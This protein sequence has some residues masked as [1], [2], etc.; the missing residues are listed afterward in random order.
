MAGNPL[1]SIV[2]E[3]EA[4]ASLH[5]VGGSGSS[6]RQDEVQHR[7]P[8]TRI[9]VPKQG[10]TPAMPSSSLSNTHSRKQ[11]HRPGKSSLPKHPTLFSAQDRLYTDNSHSG[12]DDNLRETATRTLNR[13]IAKRTPSPNSQTRTQPSSPSNGVSVVLTPPSSNHSKGKGK[14]R[15]RETSSSR[16]TRSNPSRKASKSERRASKTDIINLDSD[17][18][19][20][21]I[22]PGSPPP[23]R[24]HRQKRHSGTTDI[25]PALEAKAKRLKRGT[26]ASSA[27]SPDLFYAFSRDQPPKGPLRLEEPRE[28][29]KHDSRIVHVRDS[30]SPEPLEVKANPRL[31]RSG[32]PSQKMVDRMHPRNPSPNATAASQQ[33]SPNGSSF[34]TTPSPTRSLSS[35]GQPAESNSAPHSSKRRRTDQAASPLQRQGDPFD[36]P[37]EVRLKAIVVS[38]VWRS[39]ED[40]RPLAVFQSHSLSFSVTPDKQVKISYSDIQ[41]VVASQEEVT[42]HATL[43]F[44]LRCGSDSAGRV[45]KTFSDYDPRASGGAAEIQLIAK[46]EEID[47]RNHRMAVAFVIKKGLPKSKSDDFQIRWLNQPSSKSKVGS[48]DAVKQLPWPQ[49]KVARTL[50]FPGSDRRH[51]SESQYTPRASASFSS[52]QQRRKT[53]D[54]QPASPKSPAGAPIDIDMSDLSPSRKSPSL[55]PLTIPKSKPAT[56]A[57]PKV[58]TRHQILAA[59]TEQIL[60]YPYEGV[61][62]MSING[63]DFERLLDGQLLNDIIIEFGLKFMLGEIRERDADLADSIYVFNTFFCKILMDEPTVESS[64][65]K[66]RRWTS[67]VDL[68]SK[69]YIVVPINEA[70]H[71][72]LAVIVNPGLMLMDPTEERDSGSEQ[73]KEEVASAL[74]V[75]RI[76]ATPPPIAPAA[77]SARRNVIEGDAR[78]DQDGLSASLEPG[79]S[80]L[81][82]M[83]SLIDLPPA[84]APMDVDRDSRAST[85]TKGADGPVD[86]NR[87][88]IITFD[89]LGSRHVRLGNKL[90]EYLWR[91]ALDKNRLTAAQLAKRVQKEEAKRTG[92]QEGE[93]R[94]TRAQDAAQ[95]PSQEDV[96]DVL[97]NETNGKDDVEEAAA[98]QSSVR[99]VQVLDTRQSAEGVDAETLAKSLPKTPYIDA[100]VPSQPNFCD[101]GIYLLHYFDR[102]FHE[103]E[104]LL[105]LVVEGKMKISSV[106]KSSAAK[107]RQYRDEVERSAASEWQAGEVSTKRAYWRSKILDLSDEWKEHVK[108]KKAAE[109]EKKQEKDEEREPKP[110]DENHAK[111]NGA[112][113]KHSEAEAQISDCPM[114][115]AEQLIGTAGSPDQVEG[116]RDTGAEKGDDLESSFDIERSVNEYAQGRDLAG[117]QA[118]DSII[119]QVTSTPKETLSQEHLLDLHRN[120]QAQ[121]TPP[122]PQKTPSEWSFNLRPHVPRASLH[123][124]TG[125]TSGSVLPQPSD[126]A[127]LPRVSELTGPETSSPTLTASS[128]A[129][130]RPIFQQQEQQQHH[131]IVPSFGSSMLSQSASNPEL[132]NPLL[133]ESSN[134]TKRAREEE[135][136]AISDE[137]D[138]SASVA[139]IVAPSP[140]PSSSAAADGM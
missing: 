26:A 101:C 32:R 59:S 135:D 47:L 78:P 24:S 132:Q 99:T 128:P 40:A 52:Q 35:S 4:I 130:L 63:R 7:R 37:H 9:D 68:F 70:Y 82:P 5:G 46:T 114:P 77:E 84:P 34:K 98:V 106:N 38:D 88:F 48:V 17:N 25:S 3:R 6:R 31:N 110:D 127:A 81:P 119:A 23:S 94:Q 137:R 125:D 105:K 120:E 16:P 62:A 103:P 69:K 87:T 79:T 65:R 19:D 97:M 124:P 50:I 27:A 22:Q 75:A 15:D 118:V 89:S 42:D 139:E 96:D 2:K 51:P 133:F 56:Y 140:S 71:W 14:A 45:H 109:A 30:A 117:K 61:G 83:R 36:L 20:D 67:K 72:Y 1:G 91:E 73:D 43:G 44:T 11:P 33:A 18:E 74:T 122:T 8:P 121:Q 39:H 55:P 112:Q 93:M 49:P 95:K 21:E 123:F 116:N 136:E 102:F 12:Y 41:Q 28:M 129:P 134:D 104:K 108:A 80:P 131:A 115:A 107:R 10:S 85:P 100:Q 64:Y 113:Q 57:T 76:T 58:D 13:T 60:Q 92:Q 126:S 86:L 54:I 111:E 138:S 90:H 53:F 29:S 66:L